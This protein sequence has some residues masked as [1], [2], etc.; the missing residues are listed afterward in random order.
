MAAAAFRIEHRLGIPAPASVIWEVLSD[1]PRWG[2]W[3]PLYTRAEGALR[4][5]EALALTEAAPGLQPAAL[6]PRIVDWVPDAQI[7]WRASERWGLVSRL[8]YL[9]I[10]TLSDEGCIFANGEDWYGRFARYVDR[11]RRRALYEGME[12]MSHALRERA[13][14][15]WRA[16]GEA[17]TSRAS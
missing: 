8:R 2:E 1:L 12:A 9:E 15:L 11:S 16:G 3:N 13:I 14:E 7:L 10:E 17:P 4:I 6:N 5:G